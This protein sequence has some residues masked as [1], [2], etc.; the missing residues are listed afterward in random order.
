MQWQL[1][2]DR[3]LLAVD[4]KASLIMTTDCPTHVDNW[5]NDDFYLILLML[6]LILQS[7]YIFALP[8]QSVSVILLLLVGKI[9]IT[10][11]TTDTHFI[12]FAYSGHNVHHMLFS[13]PSYAESSALLLTTN[14]GAPGIWC[15]CVCYTK[16]KRLSE[17]TT[18]RER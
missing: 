10:F 6:I 15:V 1:W 16:R 11:F 13:L 5:Y 3:P 18:K 2:L 12:A 9:L 14:T 8:W 4:F 7:I 17:S